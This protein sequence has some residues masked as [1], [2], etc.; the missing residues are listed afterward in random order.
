MLFLPGGSGLWETYSDSTETIASGSL[1][2]GGTHVR[3]AP[4]DVCTCGREWQHIYRL[5]LPGI[6]TTLVLTGPVGRWSVAAVVE[7]VLDSPTL[8]VVV[9]LGLGYVLSRSCGG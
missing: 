6:E 5:H 4:F 8:W 9:A 3:I 2:R 1:C 7:L